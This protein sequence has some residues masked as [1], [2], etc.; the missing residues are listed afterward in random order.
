MDASPIAAQLQEA[1]AGA[2]IEPVAGHDVP[3]LAVSREHLVDLC[4]VLRDAPEHNYALLSDLTCVDVWPRGPRFEVVYNLV[5]LGVAGFPRA[6]G[7]TQPRR[8]RLIVRLTGEDASVPTVSGVYPAADWAEREVYDLF[9][10]V[11]T[12]HPDLRRILMPDEWEGHPLRKDY[13]VQVNVPVRS[14]EPL[15]LSEDE[16]VANMERLRAHQARPR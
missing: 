1:V 9:G 8:L 14:H 16:F 3:T 5:S 15:Q 2:A 10:I 11:F 4:R 7:S 6:G 13:P 12:G